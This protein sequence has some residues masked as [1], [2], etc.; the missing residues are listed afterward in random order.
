MNAGTW[1]PEKHFDNYQLN[2]KV[3]TMGAMTLLVDQRGA[4]LTLSKNTQTICLHYPDG[5]THRVGIYALGKILV[6]GE[7]V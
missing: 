7:V 5:K 4:E 6:Y 1:E 3:H 2:K